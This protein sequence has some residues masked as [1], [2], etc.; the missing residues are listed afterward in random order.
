M[1]ILWGK[2]SEDQVTGSEGHSGP[3]TGA[4]GCREEVFGSDRGPY[5]SVGT[6]RTSEVGPTP[7]RRGTTHDPT[8][9]EVRGYGRPET[10]DNF[11]DLVSDRTTP[12][13]NGT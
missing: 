7:V 11:P 12:D 13:S 6:L 5:R 1:G 10:T 2:T 3:E 8:P 4:V 9:T